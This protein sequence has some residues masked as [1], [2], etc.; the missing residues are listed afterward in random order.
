MHWRGELSYKLSSPHPHLASHPIPKP[1]RENISSIFS[2]F[3][4][5]RKRVV[6]PS[7]RKKFNCFSSYIQ[8]EVFCNLSHSKILQ[9]LVRGRSLNWVNHVKFRVPY[10]HF[11]LILNSIL[12]V[13]YRFRKADLLIVIS[14]Q[15]GR[16]SV[17]IAALFTSTVHI[18]GI[19]VV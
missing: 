7:L 3:Y 15:P 19:L 4:F 2:L 11:I 16:G 18:Y 6:S 9:S 13:Y 10:F 8:R 14:E 1:R 5:F 12:A 17:R